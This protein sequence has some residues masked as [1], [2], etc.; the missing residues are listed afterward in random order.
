MVEIDSHPNPKHHENQ[1]V[2]EDKYVEVY[3]QNQDIFGE[4]RKRE[5]KDKSQTKVTQNNCI[6]V[7]KL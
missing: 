1:Q 2:Q 6:D 5:K 3:V 7:N 4:E